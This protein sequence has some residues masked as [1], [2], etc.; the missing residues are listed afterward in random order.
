MKKIGFVGLGTM[1][2]PIAT[3][4]VNAGY[5][6][7]VGFNR[8]RKPAEL[9]EK[10]G[11]VICN[12][13][14]EVAQNSDVIFTVVPNA[15][16]V[17]QVVFGKDGLVEGIK[18]GSI[19]MDM[20]TID[21]TRSR[22][23]A[24]RL[25][26][27]GALFMDAPVS[28]GPEG[29]SAATLAIMVGGD[30]QAFEDSREILNSVGKTVVYC[31]SNGLGL[32]AKMANNLIAGAEMAAIAEAVCLAAKAGINTKDLYEILRNASAN[33]AVLNAKMPKYLEENYDPSFKLSLM[34]KDLNIITDVG[35]KLGSPTPVASMVEQIF[36]MCNKEHG[37]K[38]S[39]AVALFYQKQAGI[40]FKAKS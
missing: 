29:A 20:S 33:S 4:L 40:T 6:L 9:M 26:E 5:Q 8:N 30:K 24:E 32:A 35:K 17:E 16:E 13:Y 19:I 15:N 39:G 25:K 10:K 37:E 34:Y 23:F 21:L 38:D 7:Y 22:E 1:G 31:G 27:K 3:N 36:G 11:A 28:G 14:K 2:L 12:T 18:P